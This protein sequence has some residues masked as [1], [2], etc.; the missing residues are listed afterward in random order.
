MTTSHSAHDFA[1]APPDRSDVKVYLIGGGIASLSA[2][3]FLIRDGDSRA[4]T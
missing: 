1:G 3:A 4:R 2:A